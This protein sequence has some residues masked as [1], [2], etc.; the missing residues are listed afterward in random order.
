MLVKNR[1]DLISAI[2][3]IVLLLAVVG[4]FAP[5]S[6]FAEKWR[7]PIYRDMFDQLNYKFG[8]KPRKLPADSVP[9]SGKMVKVGLYDFAAIDAIANPISQPTE[10]S[11]KHGKFLFET[12]CFPCHGKT[13]LGD[14]PLLTKGMPGP[15]LQ[16]D[17][18]KEKT[19]GFLWTRILQGTGALMPGHAEAMTQKEAWEVVNY[20]RSLQGK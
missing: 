20:I 3:S 5:S 16:T 6:A 2:R 12:F 11:L 19:D 7:D 14:G 1:Q 13:G 18:Y 10:A 17:M 15:N 9:I 4:V 8:E